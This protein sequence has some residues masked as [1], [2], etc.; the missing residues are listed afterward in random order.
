[1][2]SNV[3]VILFD[4]GRV[5]MH[6]DFEAFPNAL[7]L[8]TNEDRSQFD[9]AKIQ[10]NIREYETGRMSTDEF[11]DSLFEIFRRKFPKKKILDAFNMIIVS[12]NEEIIPLVE[13]MRTQYRIA[14]LSN[15][16]ECHW[17]EVMRVSSLIKFFPHLYTS[18]Q[19]G[20][21]KPD[22]V[23]Y[24]KVCAAMNV[25]PNDVVFI[26]DLKENVDGAI[27]AGMNAFQF[28][29]VQQLQNQISKSLIQKTDLK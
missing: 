9:Q 4:L 26:D 16:C 8:M 13:K 2:N 7:G 18:F 21:M 22:K 12:D 17:E 19:F 11:I 10:I 27:K 28:T 1:M 3:K 15:T 25:N 29:D 20:V 14:V 24:E 23:I 6:I 5:L